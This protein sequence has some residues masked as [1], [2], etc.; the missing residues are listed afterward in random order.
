M[1]NFKL[2]LSTLTLGLI[3][4]NVSAQQ[5]PTNTSPSGV[6]PSGQN[7]QQFWSRAGNSPFGGSNNI[8]GTN[9][10]SHSFF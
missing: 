8:F 3:S 5:L 6:V 2:K 9:F 1:K 4:I 10:N 7:N